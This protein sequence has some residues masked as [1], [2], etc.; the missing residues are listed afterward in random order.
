[1]KP[2]RLFLYLA[3]F[4]TSLFASRQVSLTLFHPQIQIDP[5][6]SR[7]ETVKSTA[8]PFSGQVNILLIHIPSLQEAHLISLWWIALAP[9][10][11]ITMVNL[12]PTLQP[13]SPAAQSLQE[14]FT[15]APSRLE[16][17]GLDLDFLKQLTAQEIPWDGYLVLDHHA[18]ATLIDYFGGVKLSGKPYAGSEVIAQ[19]FNSDLSPEAAYSFQVELWEALCEKSIYASSPASFELIRAE[20]KSHVLASPQFPLSLE[21]FHAFNTQT[22]KLSCEIKSTYE[23][24]AET[25]TTTIIQPPSEQ[26]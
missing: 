17:P 15:I 2:L 25:P 24:Q 14:H 5:I 16:K 3:I 19:W 13:D 20:L 26:K 23:A 10:S 21:D 11:P 4:L 9:H 18:L 22:Y 8:L 6:N 7:W 1:M 12:Y